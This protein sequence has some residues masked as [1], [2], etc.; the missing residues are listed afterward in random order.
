M[1]K[2]GYSGFGRITCPEPVT[3]TSFTGTFAPRSAASIFS[4]CSIGTS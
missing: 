1:V 2:S 4:E 3:R